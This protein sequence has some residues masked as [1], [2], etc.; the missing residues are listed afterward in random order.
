MKYWSYELAVTVEEG[1]SPLQFV[2]VLSLVDHEGIEL[3]LIRHGE[4]LLQN[5]RFLFVRFDRSF[6]GRPDTA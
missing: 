2:K 1:A 4:W 5:V 6:P 3:V